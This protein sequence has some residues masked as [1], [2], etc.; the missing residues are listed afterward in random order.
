[1]KKS[2]IA[3]ADFEKL[4]LRVGEVKEATL[5][6][7]SKNLIKMKVDFGEDY[8][9]VEILSGLAKWYKPEDIAGKKYGFLANLEP[10]QMMGSSSNGMVLVT[11]D[12]D[13][14]IL[15]QVDSGLQ[16]GLVIR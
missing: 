14:P 2:I 4:D 13:K 8:G 3:F 10:K 16:N 15:L 12:L 11:D 9:V 6:E 5:V 7:R 1:M